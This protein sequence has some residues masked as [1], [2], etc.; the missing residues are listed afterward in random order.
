MFKAW[1]TLAAP[2]HWY[3]TIGGVVIWR[4]FTLAGKPDPVP[5][6]ALSNQSCLPS[7]SQWCLTKNHHRHRSHV[8]CGTRIL[9]PLY[10]STF[11]SSG[12]AQRVVLDLMKRLL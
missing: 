5:D 3:S 10:L 8:L 1:G 6:G 12:D 7:Q 11:E 4:W 9:P 2:T